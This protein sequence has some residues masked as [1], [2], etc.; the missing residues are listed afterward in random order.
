MSYGLVKSVENML[1]TYSLFTIL[2][3][4]LWVLLVF[5]IGPT[6]LVKGTF[7][8]FLMILTTVKLSFIRDCPGS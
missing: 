8:V 4:E 2:P 3:Y 5:G 6:F 1:L 7:K